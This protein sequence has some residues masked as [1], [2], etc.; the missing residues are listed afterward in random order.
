MS[1]AAQRAAQKAKKG[2][3]EVYNFNSL[4]HNAAV[5]GY[6]YVF[7]VPCPAARVDCIAWG[8]AGPRRRLIAS[9][10]ASSSSAHEHRRTFMSVVAGIAVG[11]FGATG[12]QGFALHLVTQLLVRKCTCRRHGEHTHVV[13]AVKMLYY[14]C[15]CFPVCAPSRPAPMA[16]ERASR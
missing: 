11:L 5:L 4:K 16:G 10:A 7:S 3:P 1:A 9:H 8:P 15:T 13:R 12:L 2:E 14:A 6:M